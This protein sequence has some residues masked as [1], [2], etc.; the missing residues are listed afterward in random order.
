M[1][2]IS[3]DPGRIHPTPS[4]LQKPRQPSQYVPTASQRVGCD[5]RTY[6]VR[7]SPEHEGSAFT[8]PLHA[9]SWRAKAIPPDYG[10]RPTQRIRRMTFPVVV[11][12][13][14]DP[15]SPV[16]NAIESQERPDEGD[17]VARSQTREREA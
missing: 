6:A 5:R 11:T 4:S 3:R 8:I 16:S 1:S 2:G 15:E 9:V 13:E 14:P 7:S 10:L 17:K 12:R